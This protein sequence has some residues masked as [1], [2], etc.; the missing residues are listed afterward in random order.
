MMNN[1]VPKLGNLSV[2]AVI[3]DAII[4]IDT[5]MATLKANISV[6]MMA[7]E[8]VLYNKLEWNKFEFSIYLL[9]A[10]LFCN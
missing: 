9:T 10:N 3:L 4:D 7:F 8:T 5:H 1:K 2:I 6:H